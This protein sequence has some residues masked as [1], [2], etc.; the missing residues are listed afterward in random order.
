MKKLLTFLTCSALL[1]ATAPAFAGGGVPLCV[2]G[3]TGIAGTSGPDSMT[4][5]NACECFWAYGGNDR[6]AANGGDDYIFASDGNDKCYGG[7]GDDI[8]R[9]ED[10]DDFLSGDKGND[11]VDGGNGTD[12]CS[13]GPTYIDCELTPAP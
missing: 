3:C 6:V 8:V 12:V 1:L 10:G 4:G 13:N 2:I 5:T 11:T 9:G 7:Y